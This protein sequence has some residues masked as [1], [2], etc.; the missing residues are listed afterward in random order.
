[1]RV[2]FTTLPFVDYV[3]VARKQVDVSERDKFG[4]AFLALRGSRRHSH[5][6]MVP[7]ALVSVRRDALSDAGAG[8]RPDWRLLDF[9]SDAVTGGFRGAQENKPEPSSEWPPA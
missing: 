4:E 1:V 3:W 9:V 8:L 5:H 6:A 2:F 7:T